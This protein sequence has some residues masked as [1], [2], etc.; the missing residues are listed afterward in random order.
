MRGQINSLT[1]IG[2]VCDVRV[3]LH[4]SQK[5]SKKRRYSLSNQFSYIYCGLIVLSCPHRYM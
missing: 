4:L 1:S 3:R 5:V 2:L